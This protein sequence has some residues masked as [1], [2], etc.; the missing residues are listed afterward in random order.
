MKK[1]ILFLLATALLIAGCAKSQDSPV[2]ME[3]ET[4]APEAVGNG[5]SADT[6]E[7]AAY[8]NVIISVRRDAETVSERDIL[9]AEEIQAVQEIV[10]DYMV[11][12]AAWEGAKASALEACIVLSFDST[13]DSERQVFYQYD[14]EGCHVLQAG[15]NG[16][17]TIMSDGA[18]EKLLALAGLEQN[19]TV[20]EEP[21]MEK[22]EYQLIT[23]EEAM[24]IMG[25]ETGYVILDVRTEDEYAQAHIPG[26]VL[27]PDFEL[28]A[29][30]ES[31]LQ[32]KA[33][34]ILVYCRSGRRSAA[35]AKALVEMGY[36]NVKDF[37]GIIDWPYETVAE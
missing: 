11:K 21:I 1:R 8:S 22:A 31:E 5:E 25:D 26:A 9:S 16:M 30:A 34:Q 24:A 7:P 12:S 20:T 2:A 14:T 37:G 13:G 35:A 23:P 3:A 32:D 15:E 27:I 28:A 29:R 6:A 10:F 33:Q 17:Y 19:L 36:A 18:Y 4:P